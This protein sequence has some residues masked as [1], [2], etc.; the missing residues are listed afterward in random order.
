MKRLLF[1]HKFLIPRIVFASVAAAVPGL[2]HAQTSVLPDFDNMKLRFGTG[3]IVDNKPQISPIAPN[4]PGDSSKWTVIQWSRFAHAAPDN[5][6]QEDPATADSVLG[7]A[8][9]GFTAP[10]Q[11]THVW[12]YKNGAGGHPVYDLYEQGGSVSAGG[13]RNLFLST[14]VTQPVTFD[15][16]VHFSMQAKV[17]RASVSYDTP[18]AQKT[19]AVLGMAFIGFAMNFP[20]PVDGSSSVL[21]LQVDVAQSS[22]KAPFKNICRM[23]KSG[24]IILLAGG[25]LDGVPPLQF[26]ANNGAPQ[27]L[28]FDVNDYINKLFDGSVGCAVK[29]QKMQTVSLRGISKSDISLKTVYIGLETQSGDSRQSTTDHASQ[30]NVELGIQLS[31]VQMT[32]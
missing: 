8:A 9:Y 11:R 31:N 13:G 10:D 23:T 28:S 6:T 26:K 24:R 12:I 16:T 19:G 7:P 15:H 25:T 30:G 29:G 17:S 14:G 32:E 20:S 18:Q 21:F 27:T 1:R 5:M 2:A 4:I 3:N 22:N